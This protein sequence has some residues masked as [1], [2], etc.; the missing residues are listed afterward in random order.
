M[1]AATFT[2]RYRGRC[3]DCPQPVNVGDEVTRGADGGVVHADCG[4]HATS[5]LPKGARMPALCS[6]C[7]LEHAGDC[8]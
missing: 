5:V 1:S 8:P 4:D 3:A 2:A 7:W 6:T